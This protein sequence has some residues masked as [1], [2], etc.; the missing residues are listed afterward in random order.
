MGDDRTRDNSSETGWGLGA[1]TDEVLAKN[2]QVLGRV[3]A[4]GMGVVYRARDLRL[5]RLVA[6]KFLPLELIASERDKRHILNEAR[7]A[8][9]LDH[10]NIGVIHGFEELEDGR[11]FIVMAFYEGESLAQR[12]LRVGKLPLA[13]AIDVASQMGAG[14]GEAHAHHIIH[15][16]IKP[17]NVMLTPQG[18][19]KIVDFGLAR[20]IEQTATVTHGMAGTVDYMSPEQTM[21]DQL[22]HRTDLWSLG[23]VL[24]QMTTGQNPFHRDRTSATMFAIMNTPPRKM[25][26]LPTDLQQVIYRSLGKERDDRYQSAAEF[27]EDLRAVLVPEVDGAASSSRRSTTSTAALRR[28][29]ERAS[30]SVWQPEAAAKPWWQKWWTWAGTVVVLLLGLLATPGVRERLRSP[31][32]TASALHVA[33]LPFTNLGNVPGNEALADG[34][35]DSL[36]GELSNLKVGDKSLWVV[37]TS[38]VRRLNIT[39]PSAALKQLGATM[40]VKGS[41]ARDGDD[42]RLNVSLIDTT[43]MRQ[44]GSVNLEDRAGD[45]SA[46]Q[47]EAVAQ[48]ARLMKIDV[49]ADMLKNTGGSVVP[50]AYEQYLQ[51]NGYMQRYDKPGNLDQAIKSLETAVKADPRFALGYAQLAEAYRLQYVHDQNPRHLSEA[52]ANS[53]KALELDDRMPAAYVTLGRIHNKSGNNDLAVGEF[54][55]ALDLDP[56][57]SVA[58]MG[59]GRSYETAGR[60]KDAEDAFQKAADA[61]PDNWDGYEELGLFYNR[62]N[63]YPEAI[64]AYKRALELTPDNAQVYLNL[65]GAYLDSG[66]PK[67]LPEAE[68]ALKKS[69]ELNPIY[70]VYANLGVLYGQEKRYAEAA[71]MTEK[72]LALN[73][74]DY[75]VWD[76]LAGYYKWLDKKDKLEQTRAKM[77]SLVES[78]V[79]REPRDATAQAVLASIYAERG[80]K[81]KAVV[82]IRTAKQLAP[83][84]PQVLQILAEA[85]EKLGDRKEALEYV[86]Q[87]LQKGATLD[88][89]TGDADLQALL[90]DPGFKVPA[91]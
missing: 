5:E 49:T 35:M 75:L 28:T 83:G 65:G 73:S 43:D 51:A 34:L 12:L 27:L 21:G 42:V 53:Q 88:S 18:V 38:E 4:G 89:F 10:P 40:V 44:V 69:L 8:S 1:A 13:Q 23:V 9:V 72:A 20:D 86:T 61:T 22:D 47:N 79:V 50:A 54:R 84:D 11:C 60:L 46:L 16:D 71:E 91:K 68:R 41:V 24:A 14:L 33:V 36:A 25:P 66:D 81:E 85:A 80:M 3:G 26:E 19:A 39:E 45:F 37:P 17:S 63:K 2:Y 59:L 87:A 62:Q 64:A 30:I 32:T 70:P 6:L 77:L 52:I 29:M 67:V 48:L 31:V 57:N 74:N 55:K 56:R 78:A 7:T 76:N 82:R 58:L 90:K 15:R